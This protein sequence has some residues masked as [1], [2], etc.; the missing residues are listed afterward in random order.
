MAFEPCC[1]NL[2]ELWYRIERVHTKPGHVYDIRCV[3]ATSNQAQRKAGA[4]VLGEKQPHANTYVTR[5]AM[6]IGTSRPTQADI[7]IKSN[8]GEVRGGCDGQL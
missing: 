6:T 5:T 2:K 8:S 3:H 4:T 7:P 1:L